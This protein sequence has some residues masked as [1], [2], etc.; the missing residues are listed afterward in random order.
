L[1]KQAILLQVGAL[2]EFRENLT[3]TS[4]SKIAVGFHDLLRPY[5]VGDDFRQYAPDRELMG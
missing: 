1:I 5:V 4:T 2:Y 3:E